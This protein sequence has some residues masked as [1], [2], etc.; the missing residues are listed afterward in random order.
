MDA[1]ADAWP[2]LLPRG[3]SAAAASTAGAMISSV[4]VTIDRFPSG[5]RRSG[6]AST[7]AT[8]T[9]RVGVGVG[10]GEERSGSGVVGVG[11]GVL[12]AGVFGGGAACRTGAAGV[13]VGRGGALDGGRGAGGAEGRG[14]GVGDGRCGGG[15]KV[16]LGVGEGAGGGTGEGCGGGGHRPSPADSSTRPPWPLPTVIAAPRQPWPRPA[17]ASTRT[18]SVRTLAPA[19]SRCR[20]VLSPPGTDAPGRAWRDAAALAASWPWSLGR[21]GSPSPGGR[22]G[23]G[24]GSLPAT[25]ATHAPS[26]PC[27]TAAARA[28]RAGRGAA[29][30]ESEGSADVETT[31]HAIPREAQARAAAVGRCHRYRPVTRRAC[32]HPGDRKKVFG[33]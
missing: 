33:R 1:L 19:P 23:C 10:E 18:S 12:G 27:G 26:G 28:A 8:I 25:P 16:G 9:L 21:P 29:P 31:A 24:P 14:G 15:E 11:A 3:R 2:A 6:A 5:C 13:G 7:G 17:P 22:P 20:S 32:G 30:G 4:R